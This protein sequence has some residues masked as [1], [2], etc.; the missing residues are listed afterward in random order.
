MTRVNN[1]KSLIKGTLLY[2]IGNFG[3]KILSFLIVPLYTYYISR[4]AM[5]DFDLVQTTVNLFAPLITLRVSDASYRW[6]LHGIDENKRCISATYRVVLFTSLLALAILSVVNLVIPVNYFWYFAGF[7]VFG[8]WLETLQQLL[9]GLKKQTLFAASGILFTAI[10]LSLNVLFIVVLQ[11]GVDALFQS[12]LISEIATIIFILVSAKELRTGII[13]SEDNRILTKELL[14]YS[15]PLIPSGLCWWV[16]SAS[17][18]YVIRIFLGRAATGIYAVANKF[19]TIVSTIFQI[20]NYSWT[21]IAIGNLKEGEETT[22]Y[23]S[24][25]FK[26]LYIISFTFLLFLIPATKLV[27]KTILSEAYKISS[28]YIGFLYLG[29]VFQG[30]TTFISAGMLQQNDT[31]L[32]ARS[33]TIGAIINLAADLIAM[34]FIG[35]HAASISTFLGGFIMWLCRMKDLEKISPIRINRGLFSLLLLLSIIMATISIWSDN[36][37]DIIL[38]SICGIVFILTNNEMLK[39][40]AKKLTQKKTL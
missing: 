29:A 2:A 8:R 28:I 19:P 17:D 22:E 4:E 33:S 10:Y 16:M 20:F 31:K 7:L 23:S 11:Q 37:I 15:L 26:Q 39:M 1:G 3:T 21:D 13:R 32:I 6:M 9:R 18:R 5:G 30:L 12:T 38:A 24:R 35:L 34:K 25:L 40:M 14:K 27:T 36:T